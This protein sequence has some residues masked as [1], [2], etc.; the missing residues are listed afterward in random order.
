V[1]VTDGSNA[2]Q[3]VDGIAG[4]RALTFAF[5]GALQAVRIRGYH[6]VGE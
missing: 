1:A 2:T 3:C 4:R 5:N 6:A